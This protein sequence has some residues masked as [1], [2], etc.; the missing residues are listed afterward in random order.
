[1]SVNRAFRVVCAYTVLHPATAEALE[2][3]AP[4]AELVDVSSDD[5]AYWRLVRDLWA[6]Q[7]DFLLIE[8]DIEITEDVLRSVADCSALWCAVRFDGWTMDTHPKPFAHIRPES[9]RLAFMAEQNYTRAHRNGPPLPPFVDPDPTPFP[10]LSW[11]E[12]CLTCNRFRRDVM[13]NCPDLVQ[14]IENRSWRSLDSNFLPRLEARGILVH[15]HLDARTIHHKGRS[16][17]PQNRPT[18]HETMR[19]R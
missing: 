7:E 4:N 15:P 2:R 18:T 1:M 19:D 3:F 5:E 17:L 6:D 14:G 8:H 9:R 13:V 16:K 11:L 12:C 10:R